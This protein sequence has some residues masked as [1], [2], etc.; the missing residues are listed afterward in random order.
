VLIVK[1]PIEHLRRVLVGLAPSDESEILRRWLQDHPFREPIE[2]TLI[3]VVPTVPAGVPVSIPAFEQWQETAYQAAQHSIKAAAAELSG[4]A[5][6]ATGHVLKGDAAAVI[7]QESRS[8]D[9][10][11]VGAHGYKGLDRFLMGSVSHHLSHVAPC[12][13][14][15]VR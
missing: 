5:V 2:L 14:L 8:S 6:R 11:V 10:V 13:V 4:P 1:R 12:S 9:L 7:G 15:V 3:S